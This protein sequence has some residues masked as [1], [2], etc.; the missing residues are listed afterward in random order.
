MVGCSGQMVGCGGQ[1]VGCGGQM[2]GCGGQMVSARKTPVVAGVCALNAGA[3]SAGCVKLRR[4]LLR[5]SPLLAHAKFAQRTGRTALRYTCRPHGVAFLS[6]RSGLD[7]CGKPLAH[8]TAGRFWFLVSVAC[9]HHRAGLSPRPP[10]RCLQ[11]LQVLPDPNPHGRV[12]FI[13]HSFLDFFTT[14]HAFDFRHDFRF[15]TLFAHRFAFRGLIACLCG[16][17]VQSISS[18][19]RTVYSIPKV[20]RQIVETIPGSNHMSACG[21]AGHNCKYN[22]AT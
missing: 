4:S 21:S 12:F 13:V 19:C 8:P 7:I 9:H 18:D 16:S 1:M 20:F 10:F 5:W 14:G 2:V 15:V 6:C 11:C 22:G 17:H 3:Q